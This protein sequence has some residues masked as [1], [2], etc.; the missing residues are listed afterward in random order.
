MKFCRFCGQEIDDD[1]RFCPVCGNSTDEN[2]EEIHRSTNTQQAK[3]E[4]NYHWAA[5][6]ALIF[7]ILGGLLAFVFGAIGLSKCTEK[8][9]KTL[10]IVGMIIAVVMIAATIA[11]RIALGI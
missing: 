11:L 1:A 2:S 10:C 6:C 4:Q 7:G 3:P 9:D 8:S 5:V